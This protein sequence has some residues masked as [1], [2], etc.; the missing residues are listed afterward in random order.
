MSTNSKKPR[1]LSTTTTGGNNSCLDGEGIRGFEYMQML[2]ELQK[3]LENPVI[4]Y[5]D[6]VAPL[7][8]QAQAGFF[9]LLCLA[10]SNN[11]LNKSLDH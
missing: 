2:E 4:Q 6:W 7:L 5:F 11:I 10:I 8:V 1:V 9:P 3:S